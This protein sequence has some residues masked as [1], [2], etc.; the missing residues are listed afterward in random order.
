MSGTTGESL[1][2][3]RPGSALAISCRELTKHY[4]GGHGLFDLDLDAGTGETF[5]FI[6]PNGAGNSTTIRL[7]IDLVRPDRG[8]AQV[9][10][11]DA[12]ADSVAVKRR[13]GYLPGELMQFPGV[14]AGYVIGPADRAAGRGRRHPCIAGSFLMTPP[15]SPA[16]RSS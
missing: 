10:G 13:V 5:G 16:S 7:L 11:L 3:A 12:H 8:A 4:G 6:G 1:G 2:D 14:T 15:A 9:L